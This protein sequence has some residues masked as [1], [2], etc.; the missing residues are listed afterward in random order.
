[1]RKLILSAILLAG[2]TSTGFSQDRPQRSQRTPE[3]RAQKITNELDQKLSLSQK[4]KQEIYKINLE[5]AQSR[6]HAQG[7]KNDKSSSQKREKFDDQDDKI[8]KVLNSKQRSV[9]NE[10]KAERK[11]KFKNHKHGTKKEF[12]KLKG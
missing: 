2:L 1:M 12:K 8:S 9:Y 11:G 6:Q 5:R 3:E 7:I 10:Y 4:Q